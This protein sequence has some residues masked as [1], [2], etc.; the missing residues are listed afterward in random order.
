MG[1]RYAFIVLMVFLEH[2]LSRG[3]YRRVDAIDCVCPIGVERVLAGG[4]GRDDD[5][6]KVPGVTAGRSTGRTAERHDGETDDRR[7]PWPSGGGA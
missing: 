1:S 2:H 6:G 3:D 5:R 4:D 7:A